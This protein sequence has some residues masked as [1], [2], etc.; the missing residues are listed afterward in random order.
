MLIKENGFT[1][2]KF[3]KHDIPMTKYKDLNHYKM[4]IRDLCYCKVT[5]IKLNCHYITSGSLVLM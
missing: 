3:L 4:V 5:I 2:S 1:T